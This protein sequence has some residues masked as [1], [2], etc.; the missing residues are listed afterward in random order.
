MGLWVDLAKGLVGLQNDGGVVIVFES[1][2]EGP[3]GLG[4]EA[5]Q[6]AARREALGGRAEWERGIQRG[7][8]P[9]DQN[10]RLRVGLSRHR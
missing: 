9:S 10:L 5:R 4:G 6:G 1:G 7:R 3:K 8:P 2:T